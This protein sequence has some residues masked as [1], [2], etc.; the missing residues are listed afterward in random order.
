MDNRSQTRFAISSCI[1]NI[2]S[3][4]EPPAQN[5]HYYQPEYHN[6]T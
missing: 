5:S 4:C 6:V 2:C 3:F 1:L